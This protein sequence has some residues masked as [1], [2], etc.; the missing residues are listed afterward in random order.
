MA[1]DTF[2]PFV[3]EELTGANRIRVAL[4]HHE[5]PFGAP[6]KHEIF[7]LGGENQ[8]KIIRLSGRKT[9]IV[10]TET[11]VWEPAVV[12]GHLRD[13]FSGVDGRGQQMV[14]DLAQIL[15][16][17]RMVKLSC[18]PWTWKAFPDKFKLPV[19]GLNDFRYELHFDV[20]ERPNQRQE[21]EPPSIQQ[22]PF[23]A[24][25]DIRAEL[26]SAR[27]ALLAERISVALRIALIADF[28]VLD[29]ALADTQQAAQDF[30]N[31]PA[32][33]EAEAAA[34]S[35][36]A[37]ATKADCTTLIDRLSS[38]SPSDALIV[39]TEDAVA[40][41]QASSMAVLVDLWDCQAQ[42]RNLQY[43]AN[44]RVRSGKQIY[45]VAPGDT[46]DSIAEAQLHDGSRAQELGY[47]ESDLRPGR[48]I[49]I[50]AA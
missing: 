12:K 4:D 35:S 8:K 50:P 7:T 43:T 42:M 20:L 1:E 25:A 44:E 29:E 27:A 47:A 38:T 31:A 21:P 15:E 22:Y 18:G 36:K 48:L 6:R 2:M 45:Q 11:T 16:N 41:F 30:E 39:T 34:M 13:H 3:I 49:R 17:Q 46:L 24:T 26:L 5:T 33:A 19:E 32:R 10:H 28:D 37:E 14:D 23:D 40:S 9:P